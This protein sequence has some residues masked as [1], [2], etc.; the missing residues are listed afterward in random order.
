MGRDARIK[1]RL[2]LRE[3]RQSR[4]PILNSAS[5]S[6]AG[7]LN[8]TLKLFLRTLKLLDTWGLKLLDTKG[9]K[10]LDT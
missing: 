7:A 6:E 3:T 10:L 1:R 2:D 9:L 5:N 4:L 8:L